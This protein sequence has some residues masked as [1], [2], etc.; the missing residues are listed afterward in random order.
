MSR[1]VFISFKNGYLFNNESKKLEYFQ[2]EKAEFSFHNGEVKYF[3][4]LAGADVVL[5]DVLLYESEERF[6]QGQD[7]THKESI[8]DGEYRLRKMAWVFRT[9]KA[10][11]TPQ[12]EKYVATMR[13]QIELANGERAYESSEEAYDFNDIVVKEADGTERVVECAASKCK[14]TDIQNL[15]LKQLAD[16]VAGMEKENLGF[17]YD[18]RDGNVK[19]INKTR[20]E[21][22]EIDCERYDA[23]EGWSDIQ[24]MYVP[25]AI[26]CTFTHDDDFVNAKFKD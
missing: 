2:F 15:Y 11:P 26:H 18:E 14:L 1:Q 7:Y 9:G 19:V 8:S 10:I 5:D 6:K 21:K 4:K 25:T 24:N 20:I 13:Y 16:L 3:G 17:I 22:I 23:C 12:D